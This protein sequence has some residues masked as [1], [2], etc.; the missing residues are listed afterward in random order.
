MEMVGQK[1]SEV[2]IFA[3]ILRTAMIGVRKSHIVYQ[4]NLNFD[5]VE[6]YL[7][8]L[9]KSNLINGPYEN[10]IFRTTKKGQKYLDHFEGF[11]KYVKVAS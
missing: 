5:I 6:K 8:L 3:D 4:A 10:K 9:K 11:Q 7:N 1:R 2:E